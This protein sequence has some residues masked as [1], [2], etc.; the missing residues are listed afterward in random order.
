MN[1]NCVTANQNCMPQK[2]LF[3]QIQAL[4]FAI[5]DLALYLNTHPNDRKAL[6]L[7]NEYATSYRNYYN[8]YERKYGPL[9]IY[10]PVSKWNWTN[11]FP[12]EGGNN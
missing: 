3:N 4:A 10:S 9:T 7:H 8:E 1:Y 5:N 12:W 11:N 6:S 2:E